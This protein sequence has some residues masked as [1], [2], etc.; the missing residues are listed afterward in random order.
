MS[1]L[2]STISLQ[3]L[4]GFNPTNL[5]TFDIV[6]AGVLSGMFVN[7]VIAFD[8]GTIDVS[9]PTSGCA[10]GYSDCIDLTYHAPTAAEPGSLL[11]LAMALAALLLMLPRL[12]PD[13]L[14][15]L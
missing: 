13:R 5:E 8:G 10:A 4:N 14:H 2:G 6:N 1:I 3:D 12:R 15:V 7:N 9:Y 11:L